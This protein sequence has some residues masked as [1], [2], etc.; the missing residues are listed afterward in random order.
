MSIDVG[1]RFHLAPGAS[2]VVV[3]R[4]VQEETGFVMVENEIAGTGV[5]PYLIKPD[6]LA[7]ATTPPAVG[8]TDQG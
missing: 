5:Y 4:E 6:R 1:D 2:S 8:G 7:P 3:V